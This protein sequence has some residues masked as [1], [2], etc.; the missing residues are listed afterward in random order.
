MERLKKP[1]GLHAKMKNWLFFFVCLIYLFPQVILDEQLEVF[2]EEELMQLFKDEKFVIVLL[3]KN[4][5]CIEK[6]QTLENNLLSIREDLVED[7]G[8][9]VVRSYS[10]SYFKELELKD[11]TILFMREQRPLIY[12]GDSQNAEN[13]LSYFLSNKISA[14]HNLTDDDFEHKTQAGT[15][16]TTGD[17]LVMFIRKNSEDYSHHFYIA[18]QVS[19]NLKGRMNV[20]IVE[21]EFGPVTSRR[22][23]VKYFPSYIL[24]RLGKLYR[25]GFDVKDGDLLTAFAKDTY[26]N[27]KAEVVPPP[28]SP[29]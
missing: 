8:G 10:P 3:S 6:C 11:S 26:R 7:T 19:V 5:N 22:F 28:K 9:W 18:E 24:F 12:S 14:V 21:K 25:Y 15:G 29:L 23:G 13:L 1:L 2:K 17:W 27:A 16:A 20:G 4:E